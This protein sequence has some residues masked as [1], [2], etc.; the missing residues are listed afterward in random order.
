MLWCRSWRNIERSSARIAEIDRDRA[1]A[2][3]V[4]RK[5]VS[6]KSSGPHDNLEA[7]LS[8]EQRLTVD[9]V[10]TTQAAAAAL[11]LVLIA[12]SHPQRKGREVLALANFCYNIAGLGICDKPSQKTEQSTRI[13]QLLQPCHRRLRI[14]DDVNKGSDKHALIDDQSQ[15]IEFVSRESRFDAI[16][17]R[18]AL[19]ERP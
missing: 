6:T 12:T 15:P 18:Q 13:E 10:S 2:Q 9:R 4:K 8:I 5:G 16:V 17:P 1:W 11:S 7:A 14:A 3:R 19:S